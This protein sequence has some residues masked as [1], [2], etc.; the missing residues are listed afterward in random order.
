M[1]AEMSPGRAR[2]RRR[3]RNRAWARESR[4]LHYWMDT[5]VKTGWWEG[6]GER[7]GHT[8]LTLSHSLNSRVLAVQARDGR[9]G[10]GA[11]GAWRGRRRR[12]LR[13]GLVDGDGGG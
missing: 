9:G 8:K 1:M 4:M 12:R 3:R 11:C 13:S 6:E 5:C 2:H 7:H 10:D